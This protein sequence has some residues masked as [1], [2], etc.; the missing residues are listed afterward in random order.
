[1]FLSSS[2]SAG[3]WVETQKQAGKDENYSDYE[4]ATQAEGGG[5]EDGAEDGAEAEQDQMQ[6]QAEGDEG[7]D[8]GEDNGARKNRRNLVDYRNY[9][10]VE[11]ESCND[12]DCWEDDDGI[13]DDA[14]AQ[15][16]QNIAAC[17]Q[18]NYDFLNDGTGTFPLYSGFM[19]NQD[20][21]G[22]EIALFLDDT[23]SIYDGVHSY[24]DLL[25]KDDTEDTN[26]MEYLTH[27]TS[28]IMF[29]FLHEINCNGELQYLSMQ[30]YKNYAQNYQYEQQGGDQDQNMQVSDYC[31]NLFDGEN[32]N[33]EAISLQDCNAD[34]DNDQQNN[35]GEDQ[36][37][38]YADTYENGD[39]DYMYKYILS[40]ADS[41]DPVA[42][43]EVVRA[44]NGKF[45]M[46]YRWSTS[47][48]LFDYGTNDSTSNSNNRPFR[49]WLSQYDKMDITL[50]A[51]IVVG[52]S[53]SILALACVL[54]SCF[55]SAAP[56]NKYAKYAMHRRRL[57]DKRERLV[58]PATGELV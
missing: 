50:V 43:C 30:E 5:A 51:A 2:F 44:L 12:L 17:P 58:D 36:V 49:K 47:G 15:W 35:D 42:T 22:V 10:V 32:D 11:C 46:I 6:Q 20:G 52:M 8:N 29:P 14:A 40:Y 27:A 48:Q 38:E 53:L 7:E 26:D 24:Y 34:G 56:N 39:Q 9:A 37:E 57:D 31:K 4:A 41:I 13:D 33:G 54:Y 19:C 25:S 55:S 1:L 3:S 16:V 21:S 18:T 28:M 23:C 45:E